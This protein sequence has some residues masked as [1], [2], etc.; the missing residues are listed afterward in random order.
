V[1]VSEG[2]GREFLAACKRKEGLDNLILLDFQSYV[3]LPDVL[4]SADVLLANVEPESSVFCVPSKIL[5]YLCAGRPI[6]M[7]VPKH[8][9]A[10]RVIERSQAGH[11]CDPSNPKEFLNCAQSMWTS[12]DLCARMGENARRYAELTFD[13]GRIGDLFEGVLRNGGTDAVPLGNPVTMRVSQ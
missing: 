4:A 9:L 7:S 1:L 12:R 6:L 2:I 5:S 13:I 11:V 3:Q 10:A 8:N